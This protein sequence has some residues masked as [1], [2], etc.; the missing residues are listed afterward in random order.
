MNDS[1]DVKR[2]VYLRTIAKRK[3]H[4]AFFFGNTSTLVSGAGIPPRRPQ[5]GSPWIRPSGGEGLI[6]A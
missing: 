5:G 1:V 6:R 4:D 2:H 3:V